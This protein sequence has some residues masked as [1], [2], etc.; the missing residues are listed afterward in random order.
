M[1]TQSCVLSRASHYSTPF[2]DMAI[3]QGVYAELRATGAFEG[4]D[5]AVDE[6][7]HSLEMHLPYVHHVMGGREFT[8]VPIMVGS[9]SYEREE[10]Y[11]KLL[12]R[13]IDDPD[14]VFV[15]SSDF[16]HWG[17]RFRYTFWDKSLGAIHQCIEA[18]DRKGMR[19]IEEGDPAKFHQYLKEFKNTIC[20]RHPIA[21]LLHV[22]RHCAA[23]HSAR[24]VRYEQSSR[25]TSLSDSS[26]SYASA[27]I[28][29]AP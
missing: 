28:T 27:L 1:Y 18:L 23:R 29:L 8:I 11:G 25:C 12:A 7:E 26:V 17:Q 3:D 22:L 6:D 5:L 10:E 2:G 14:N 20:G 24:F 19:L 21:V 15:V 9:L 4:M 16:C 13:Y